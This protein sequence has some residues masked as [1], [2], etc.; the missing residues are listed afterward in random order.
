M[1]APS[2]VTKKSASKKLTLGQGAA[3]K[4]N[5]VEGIYMSRQMHRAFAEFDSLGLS[6]EQRRRRL[7]KQFGGQSG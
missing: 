1:T 6:P 2:K 7:M 5:A 4:L 3:A